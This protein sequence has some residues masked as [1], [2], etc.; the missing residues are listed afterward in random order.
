MLSHGPSAS[1]YSS[2]LLEAWTSSGPPGTGKFSVLD[3]LFNDDDW[4][5]DDLCTVIHCLVQ[6]RGCHS[7]ERRASY[8]P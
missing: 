5:R 4:I 7:L 3:S 2:L 6:G 1:R 8:S